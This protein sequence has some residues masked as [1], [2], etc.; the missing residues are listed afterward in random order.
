[1]IVFH[2]VLVALINGLGLFLDEIDRIAK[3]S[4]K[5]YKEWIIL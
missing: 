2:V 3:R 1:M 5:K 4:L